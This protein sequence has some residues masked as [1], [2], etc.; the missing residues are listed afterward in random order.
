MKAAEEQFADGFQKQVKNTTSILRHSL[1]QPAGKR[2]IIKDIIL[3]NLAPWSPAGK[4]SVERY[5][6]SEIMAP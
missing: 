5:I 6:F 2:S 4:K 1:W 3:I